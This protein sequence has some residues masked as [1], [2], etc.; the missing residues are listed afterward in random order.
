MAE[1]T[2]FITNTRYPTNRPHRVILSAFLLA[3]EDL[4]ISFCL[5]NS[6]PPNADFS[7]SP[8][9]RAHITDSSFQEIDNQSA[10][11]RLRTS[12]RS[13]ST[14]RIKR[15]RVCGE[16][17]TRNWKL[18]TAFQKKALTPLLPRI[19]KIELA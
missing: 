11:A 10:R 16:L 6:V 2:Q 5:P 15:S 8:S 4:R 13:F 14:N 12:L 19:C 1:Q 9:P 7:L 17:E 3:R 18:D